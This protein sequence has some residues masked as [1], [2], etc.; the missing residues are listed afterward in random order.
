MPK[1]ELGRRIA[2]AIVG[3]PIALTLIYLGGWA[4]GL[5]MAAAAGVGAAEYYS[6][7]RARGV[8]PLVWIGVPA[9]A[10]FPILATTH[11][12]Y[13]DFSE[14]AMTLVLTLVLFSMAAVL[15]IRWPG[16][17]PMAVAASTVTG[18]LYAGGTLAFWVLLR[19]LPET[20]SETATA[21]HGTALVVFPIAVT[22][23]GDTFAYFFG[24][25]FGKSKLLEAVSP[26]KT[27]LGGLSGLAGSMLTAGFLG[28]VWL[29]SVPGYGVS[30]IWAVGLGLVLG[31]LGQVGDLAESVLKRESGV[32]DSGTILPGHGGVLDRLDALYFTVPVGFLM[33]LWIARL[34]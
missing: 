8:E 34:G 20:A 24:T 3:I 9:A 12:S 16:G 4:L 25:R 23:V 11:P 5:L 13:S 14:P 21:A 18:A 6:F 7:A 15:W 10:A 29:E 19:H 31:A 27:L 22:W 33:F 1:G 28:Y 17:N 26:K 32:K 30:W 2:V